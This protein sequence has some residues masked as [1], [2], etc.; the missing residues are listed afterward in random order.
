MLISVRATVRLLAT[1]F[2]G[3]SLSSGVAVVLDVEND[4]S[5][6]SNPAGA[7]SYGY[8]DA[9][10]GS[11]I[12]LPHS[13]VQVYGPG[14]VIHRW[15]KTPA[16]G[17]PSVNR[18]IGTVNSISDGGAGNMPPGVVWFGPGDGAAETFGA[19]RVTVPPGQGG[20]YRLESAVR[21]YLDGPASG[22]TSFH[23]TRNGVELFGQPL[24]GS[25]AAGYTNVIHLAPGDVVDF[26][27][28]RGQDNSSYASG[29]KIY[30][31]L[32]QL[33]P[34][35][36]DVEND[37]STNSN[38]AGAWSYGWKPSVN[39]AFSAL[40]VSLME[41]YGP[42]HIIHRWLKTSAGGP[43]SVNK[44]V[45]TVNS[46][47]DGGAGNIPPG[48]VW[49]GPGNTA[50]DTF[51]AIRLTIPAG[52][53]GLYRL[54]SAVRT[55]LDGPASGDTDF[56]VARNGVELFGQFMPGDSSSGYTNTITLGDGDILDFLVGRG[57]DNNSYASGLKIKARLTKVP[58]PSFD[59][60]RDYSTNANP[61]GPW[62]YGY[63]GSV[64]GTFTLL[65]YSLVQVY[66]PNHIIHRWL[67]AGAAS[68]P[69][70]NRNIGTVNSISDGGAGNIPPGVVWYGPGNTAADAFGAIR[71]T[72]PAGHAGLYR[73]ET[74]VRTYLDGPPSGDTDFHVVKNGVELFGQFMPGD[75]ATGYTNTIS[76]AEGD[77]LDFLVG[78]GQDN[79]SFASGLK[80][81][82]KL[83]QFPLQPPPNPVHDLERD[84]ST[85]ANPS[86]VWSLGW[87]GT[88]G[89]AFN[90]Y[91]HHGYSQ[92]GFDYWLKGP[93]GPASVYHNPRSNTVSGFAPGDIW[94]GPGVQGNPDN[95]S[96][97]RFTAPESGAYDLGV[98]VR[99]YI[100]S[101]AGDTDFHVLRNGTQLYGVFLAGNAAP[102]SYSNNVLLAAGDTIEFAIGRGADN[103][104]SGS[105]L[106][107]KA[108]LALTEAHSVSPAIITQPQDQVVPLGGSVT[109][110]VVASGSSPLTYQWRHKGNGIPGADGSSLVLHN[111]Q[112]HQAGDYS[113]VVGNGAGSV[114]SS[115]AVLTVTLPPSGLYD[116]EQH[117][118]T[119]RNPA[120][121][122]SYGWKP[123][124]GG[125]LTL[126][127]FSLI[128]NLGGGEV[129][130]RWLKTGAGGPPSINRNIGT[131][132][133]I[134]DGGQGNIPPGVVWFGPGMENTPETFGAIRFTVPN[135]AGGAYRVQTAVRSYLNGPISGD[136]DFHVV[137]NG[138]ELFGQFLPGNSGTGYTNVISLSV[139]D[140]VDFL[141]GR[142]LDNRAYASGLK[143]QATL[144]LVDGQPE[145]PDPTNCAPAPSGM[146]AWWPFD[147]TAQDIVGGHHGTLLGSPA[148]TLGKVGQALQFDYV[149]DAVRVP[150]NSA[151]DVGQGGGFTV[152]GWIR[153]NDLT[154]QHPIAEWND[155]QG[156]IGTHFWTSHLGTD[157][158]IASLIANIVDSNGTSHGIRSGPNLLTTTR[159]YHVALTY[160]KASGIAAIYIDGVRVVEQNL[161]S[162]TPRTSGHFYVGLRSSGTATGNRFAGAIDELGLYARALTAAEIQAIHAASHLG[163]CHGGP[164]TPPVAHI[165]ISPLALLSPGQ[166]ESIVIAGVN[167][168][169]AVVLDGSGSSDANGDALSFAWFVP[170][171]PAPF[172]TSAITA[173]SAAIGAHTVTLVVNDGQATGSATKSFEVI[174]ASEA[175][176]A[177]SEYLASSDVARKHEHALQASLTAAMKS[178]ERGQAE[179]AA[180]QLGA[181]QQKVE[182]Q[183]ASSDPDV[184]EFLVDAA[185]HV[186]NAL[187]VD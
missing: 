116:L 83:T 136:T 7:W 113:V 112:L 151:L 171:V 185:Q 100:D 9:V 29:L 18:N 17:P 173:H 169:A 76:F 5:T 147:G 44:N 94:F 87:A 36:F 96:V 110:D 109:F 42:G 111:V 155:D 170:G 134:S 71:L 174:T 57:Q 125:P 73:L 62:S 69:S 102:T 40:P 167:G 162:F 106:K 186:I 27:A 108:Q 50:A 143:I 165:S 11:F 47:S 187:E 149:N 41:V 22:D 63:K 141:V 166:T 107:I 75:S 85:N 81:K 160:D 145:P 93:G 67:K 137:K 80:I 58:T 38:P 164:N 98:A 114:T 181:F 91:T 123:S 152:E 2:L 15:L 158:Q 144:T 103:S 84:Y 43:P 129:V 51:G 148:F 138:M 56:H 14:H 176:A 12:A 142:G 61:A 34:V 168:T 45:G 66:G 156:N 20:L 157:G 97:I 104:E 16:G 31:R 86:G 24:P 175:V 135:G 1:V 180:N 35:V 120:G 153:P 30:A 60:E 6:N 172:S 79:N 182:S 64:D 177:I 54:E 65:P 128:Q 46:I 139:G 146:V 117:Y 82:A 52:Q 121:P 92:E 53:G 130:H 39:G 179:A 32:T 124:L 99:P 127:P 48:V 118:S 140:T 154:L 8:K 78:R 21:T 72:I 25:S 163:K 126:L 178:L 119:N 74:A 184:A 19:I 77:T 3:A 10:G 161:G 59:V 132:N 4:Y 133:H 88:L 105:G 122:W 115:S 89:G 33:D 183:V 95:Y 131:V 13:L 68:P 55:Y 70:V 37:Y 150:A 28:G 101:G 26:L 159:F 90:L 49:Y 23:V